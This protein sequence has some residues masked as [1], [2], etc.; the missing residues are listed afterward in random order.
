MWIFPH[1]RTKYSRKGYWLKMKYSYLW[2]TSRTGSQYHTCSQ[3]P[4]AT[5]AR[6]RR[7]LGTLAKIRYKTITEY[8]Q[9]LDITLLKL[10]GGKDVKYGFFAVK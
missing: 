4:S 2:S 10:L 9:R 5:T 7:E 3:S 1:C 8:K 6:R